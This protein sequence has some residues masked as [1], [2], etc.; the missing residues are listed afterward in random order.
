MVQKLK[1]TG[2]IQRLQAIG[3]ARI[4]QAIGMIFCKAKSHQH[5]IPECADFTM[6]KGFTM[7]RG[8]QPIP[9]YA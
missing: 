3:M 7:E 2:M 6:N 8:I 1:V 5:V 9:A 4:L